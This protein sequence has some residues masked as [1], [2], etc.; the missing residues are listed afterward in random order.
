MRVLFLAICLI[1]AMVR[2]TLAS[3]GYCQIEI[4]NSMTENVSV[5]GVFDDGSRLSSFRVYGHE[6]PHYIDLYY[7]GHC[8]SGMHLTVEE[9]H[10]PRHVLYDRWT[11]TGSTVRV[12]PYKKAAPKR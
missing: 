2:N 4:I 6:A 9:L 7:H 3:P 10:S 1:F 11:R 8:H 5:R 12:V